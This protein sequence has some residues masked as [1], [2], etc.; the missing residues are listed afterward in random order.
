MDCGASCAFHGS[1]R[2]ACKGLQVPCALHLYLPSLEEKLTQP[3]TSVSGQD[4]RRSRVPATSSAIASLGG[5][6]VIIRPHWHG[7]TAPQPPGH[8]AAGGAQYPGGCSIADGLSGARETHG[9]CRNP[10]AAML[11]RGLICSATLPEC[12][13]GSQQGTLRVPWN[14][15]PLP[16][17]E[18]GRRGGR[19]TVGAPG[20]AVLRRAARRQLQPPA[21]A[22]PR[23][24]SSGRRSSFNSFRRPSALCCGAVCGTAS[25]SARG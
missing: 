10:G 9:R 15:R 22:A 21:D 18:A 4:T 6:R 7:V 13:P 3:G 2:P 12:R 1:A 23:T 11:L 24:L 16:R 17:R 5:I 8:D 14:R 20:R 25:T 19:L